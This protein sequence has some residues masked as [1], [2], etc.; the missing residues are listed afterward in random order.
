MNERLQGRITSINRTRLRIAV[1]L[2]EGG[3][4]VADLEDLDDLEVGDTVEGELLTHGEA[5]WRSQRTG[6]ALRVYVEAFDAGA[7]NARQLLR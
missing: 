2:D 1:L 7:E 3:Y 4:T 5:I 6:R